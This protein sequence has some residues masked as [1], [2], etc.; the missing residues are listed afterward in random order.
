MDLRETY[1]HIAE[2]WHV[3]AQRPSQRPGLDV[4]LRDLQPDASVLDVGCGTGLIAGRFLKAG[5]RVTGIDISDGMLEIA[6]REH[7][8]GAFLQMD[9]L[10]TEKLEG[11]FD[12]ICAVA[13]LLHRPRH[14]LDRLLRIFCDKLK[15]GGRLFVAVKE[16]RADRP[17]EGIIARRSSRY[18]DRAFL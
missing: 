16:K 9:L 11:K 17:E 3:E 8:E 7:P 4:V 15:V 2:R 13:V 5:A 12:V 1:N 18:H 10:E 14:E 6:R